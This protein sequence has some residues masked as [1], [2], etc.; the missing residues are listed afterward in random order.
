[1]TI[2]REIAWCDACDA[3]VDPPH[4]CPLGQSMPDHYHSSITVGVDVDKPIPYVLTDRGREAC[5][6]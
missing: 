3:T 6:S 2:T 1:M 4:T 5:R